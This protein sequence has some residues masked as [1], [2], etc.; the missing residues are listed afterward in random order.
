VHYEFLGSGEVL[1]AAQGEDQVLTAS[2]HCDDEA[3]FSC[4]RCLES[5]V[6]CG[7]HIKNAVTSYLLGQLAAHCLDFRKLGHCLD[8]PEWAPRIKRQ[9][10]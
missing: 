2:A 6:R 5:G 4:M 10:A 7:E 3:T 8:R 9:C 1:R